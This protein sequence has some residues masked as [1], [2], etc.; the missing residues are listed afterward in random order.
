M[1]RITIADAVRE[2]EDLAGLLDNAYWDSAD[3]HQ[4]DLF[5]NLISLLHS[6]LN[7]LAKLSVSDH[8]MAY[9]PITAPWR[10]GLSKLRQL[11]GNIDQWVPRS[12][13]ASLL[14]SQLPTVIRIM[15]LPS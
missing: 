5:Y 14:E 15:T 11:Q 3:I 9:E 8:Y 13:T 4:K 6:E 1:E 10:N 2:L 7:E 12:K